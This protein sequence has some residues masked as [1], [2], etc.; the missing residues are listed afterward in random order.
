MD[1]RRCADEHRGEGRDRNSYLIQGLK[2]ALAN[3]PV[4][5]SEKGSVTM[6][7]NTFWICP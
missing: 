7:V 1:G 6:S 3:A 2:K 4:A 5:W